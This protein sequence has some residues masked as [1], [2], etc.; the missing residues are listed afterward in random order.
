MDPVLLAVVIYRVKEIDW[1]SNGGSQ[2]LVSY[3][4]ALGTL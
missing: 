1:S 3:E 4:F 2:A